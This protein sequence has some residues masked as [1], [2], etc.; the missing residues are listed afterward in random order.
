MTPYLKYKAIPQ[1][2]IERLTKRLNIS[3]EKAEEIMEKADKKRSS[4]YNY[5]SYNTWGAAA[6]YH[7]CIDSS[8][9]GIDQT[10]EFIKSFVKQKLQ[11]P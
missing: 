2:R 10:V 11:L 4:Y 9:L 7:L 3:E 5:Y 8:V 6:T 1:A